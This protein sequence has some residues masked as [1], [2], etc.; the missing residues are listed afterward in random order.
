MIVSYGFELFSFPLECPGIPL[1]VYNPLILVQKRGG[2]F[3]GSA[4]HF[5]SKRKYSNS[6]LGCSTEYLYHLTIQVS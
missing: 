3:L 2:S 1:Y 6:V 4:S 5:P